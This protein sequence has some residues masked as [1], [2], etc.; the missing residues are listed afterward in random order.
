MRIAI[1]SSRWPVLRQ[2]LSEAALLSWPEVPGH[3]FRVGDDALA[4]R[5]GSRS[6]PYP[7]QLTVEANALVYGFAAFCWLR[8]AQSSRRC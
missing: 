7:V 2:V 1:G 6:K 8:R 4:D 3:V 5:A